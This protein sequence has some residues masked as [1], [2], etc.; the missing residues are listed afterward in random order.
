[1]VD[2]ALRARRAKDP[3]PC[4]DDELLVAI[5]ATGGVAALAARSLLRESRRHTIVSRPAPHTAPTR[6]YGAADLEVLLSRSLG[7]D[8]ARKVIAATWAQ[9][10][11]PARVS[12][13]QALVVLDTL[14]R[15][16]GIVG[17]TARFAKARVLLA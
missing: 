10:T 6:T 17:V 13:D 11:L 4:G 5:A 3:S 15:T 14:A 1:M 2:D 7:D 12:P 16:P 8:Q 9:L